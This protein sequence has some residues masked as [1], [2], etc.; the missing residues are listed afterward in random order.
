MQRMGVR[1]RCA[2]K[3]EFSGTRHRRPDFQYKRPTPLLRFGDAEGDPT[4]NH[5]LVFHRLTLRAMRRSEP[6]MF[7][8]AFVVAKVRRSVAGRFSH[9]TVSVSSSPS[10]RLAAALSS[11]FESSQE[12]SCITSRRRI[13]CIAHLFC[14]VRP[15]SFGQMIADVACLGASS[16]HGVREIHV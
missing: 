9:I 6:F 12:A 2:R 7:S 4:T 10:R 1:A 5:F 11:P 13:V 14:D 16:R 8:I 3:L 15:P